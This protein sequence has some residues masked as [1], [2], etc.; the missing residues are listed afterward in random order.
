MMNN[1]DDT[2]SAPAI[3]DSEPQ[4]TPARRPLIAAMQVTVDGYSSEGDAD[5]VESWADGLGLLPPVDAF[6]LGA[7]MFT[8]YEQFWGAILED[9]NAVA[10]WL[11]RDVY[12]REIA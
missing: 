7:G 10:E 2:S 4:R 12:P 3:T 8:G 9:P 6:V 11:G 5:W 1:I